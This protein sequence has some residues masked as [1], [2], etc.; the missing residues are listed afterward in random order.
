MVPGDLRPSGKGEKI[1]ITLSI[2]SGVK[3]NSAKGPGAGCVCRLMLLENLN[4]GTKLDSHVVVIGRCSAENN[5]TSG[6][7]G[8]RNSVTPGELV[9]ATDSVCDHVRDE[10]PGKALER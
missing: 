4:I 5:D 10:Q 8:R 2:S 7:D 6:A 3:R 9:E 1:K